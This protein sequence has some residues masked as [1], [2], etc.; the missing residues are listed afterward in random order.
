ML[1]TLLVCA[2]LVFAGAVGATQIDTSGLTEQQVNE[3][4]IQALKLQNA[5]SEPSAPV[6]DT[7]AKVSTVTLGEAQKWADFGKNLGVA[8]VSTAK[9]L[10]I[11]VNEFSQTG[12]GKVTTAIIV[13][14]LVGR[15]IIHFVVGLI[16]MFGL[17]ALIIA[18]RRFVVISNIKYAYED[19]KA[20]FITYRKR[21]VTS[22]EHISGDN[23]FWVFFWTCAL[24][25]VSIAI[26]IV[27]MF[28]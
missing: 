28:S 14:K 11:A 16:L 10:G 26:S 4:R 17:P 8:L 24:T 7:A 1:K 22:V 2:A 21:V 12:I 9:E 25:L 18:A 15:D 27:I 6:I 13:Y 3:L 5:K 19:R 23:Q 20:W